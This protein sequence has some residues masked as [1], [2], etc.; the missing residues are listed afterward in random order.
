MSI[1]KDPAPSSC[2]EAVKP[3]TGQP[4]RSDDKDAGRI[5]QK[6]QGS[7]EKKSQET[8]GE[9]EYSS[10]ED[11]WATEDEDYYDDID[12]DSSQEEYNRGPSVGISSEFARNSGFQ[13]SKL[14]S[15]TKLLR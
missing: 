3:K 1:L 12:S 8:Q 13:V 5:G 6:G 14:Q 7:D 11:V 2:D 10:D 4:S 9:D 15:R